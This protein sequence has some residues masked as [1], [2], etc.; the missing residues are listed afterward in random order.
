LIRRETQSQRPASE[1]QSQDASLRIPRPV[2]SG[3][4]SGRPGDDPKTERKSRRATDPWIGRDDCA[5]RVRTE[6]TRVRGA[7][8]AVEPH[9]LWSHITCGATSPVEPHQVCSRRRCTATA[10]EFCELKQDLGHSEKSSLLRSLILTMSYSDIYIATFGIVL[11]SA[12]H[13][14]HAPI[15]KHEHVSR[16]VRRGERRSGVRNAQL[17]VRPRYRP[18]TTPSCRAIV[19]RASHVLE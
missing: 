12:R 11:R 4:D 5:P 16:R 15:A 7:T 17:S 3:P 1:W 10:V 13:M 9:H 18:L 6:R 2:G 8:S 19:L 14:P